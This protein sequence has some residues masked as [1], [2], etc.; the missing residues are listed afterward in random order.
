MDVSLL[1]IEPSRLL[2]SFLVSEGKGILSDEGVERIRD[3]QLV[4]NQKE[5][6]FLQELAVLDGGLWAGM[7]GWSGTAELYN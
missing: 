7:A 1:Y 6:I 2:D 4:E 3:G 5:C